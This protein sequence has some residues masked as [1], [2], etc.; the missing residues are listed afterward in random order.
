MQAPILEPQRVDGADPPGPRRQHLG[1]A[2]RRLL[3]RDRDVAPRPALGPEAA[4]ERRKGVG[5]DVD[6]LVAAG[7]AVLGEPVAVDQRRAGMVDR[8]ADDKGSVNQCFT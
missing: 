4:D 7:Q 5:M 3:V 2:E 6:T 8:V 1:E